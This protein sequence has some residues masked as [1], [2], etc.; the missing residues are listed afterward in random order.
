MITARSPT[1]S[2]IPLLG[3]LTSLSSRL[4]AQVRVDLVP[5]AGLYV[6]MASLTP[7]PVAKQA[8]SLSL[9]SRLTMWLPA[10]LGLEFTVHYAPSNVTATGEQ[11]PHCACVSFP[12]PSAA[13]VM[14]GSAKAVVRLG[15]PDASVAFHVGGGVGVVE[16]G[17]AAY[18]SD[19]YLQS[20]GAS[21]FSGIVAAGAAFKLGSSLALRVDAEDYVFKAQFQ[22]RH[23]YGASGVCW[24]VNQGGTNTSSKLQNDLVLSLGLAVRVAR[25][26]AQ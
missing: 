24:A 15:Q 17:G 13:H 22:C 20:S 19:I 18:T 26:S 23:T 5:Y 4:V 7:A 12:G 8:T 11:P 25:T 10:H 9:G 6:A 1:S 3:A 16:H 2:L 14:A 21:F